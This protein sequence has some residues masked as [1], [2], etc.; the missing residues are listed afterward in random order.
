MTPRLP[1]LRKPDHAGTAQAQRGVAIIEALVSMLLFSLGVLAMVGVHG[2]MVRAQTDAK[3][4]S[5]AA[6]LASEV[7]GKMWADL[8]NMTRYSGSGCAEQAPCQ[9]WKTKVAS[10]LP[11]GTGAITVDESTNDV[12]ITIGWQS[13]DQVSHRFVTHTTITKAEN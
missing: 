11:G 9:E 12:V 10:V 4:R 13:L 1:L 6:Y 3:L 2:S 5:D 7:T 8:K